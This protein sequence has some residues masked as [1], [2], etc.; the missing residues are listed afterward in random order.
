MLRN[1]KRFMEIDL[2]FKDKSTELWKRPVIDLPL[3]DAQT[4]VGLPFFSEEK[5]PV[6]NCCVGNYLGI[7]EI[8]AGLDASCGGSPLIGG[9]SNIH[10]ELEEYL[11]DQ[12]D[13]YPVLFINVTAA[14]QGLLQAIT[15]PL[16]KVSKGNNVDVI[17]ADKLNHSCLME[18]IYFAK[19]GFTRFYEHN[20]MRDLET[21]LAKYSKNNRKVLILTD[22]VFSME[23]DIAPLDEI[24][25]LA[26]QYG[27]AVIVDDAHAT[28]ILG[29]A[30]KGTCDYYG[31]VGDN[32]PIQI[33]SFSKGIGAMGAAV[34]VDEEF[35]SFLW[36]NCRN[37]I[38]CG[39]LTPEAAANTLRNLKI[40]FSESEHRTDLLNRANQ[41]RN[42]LI[43]MGYRVTGQ[44]N[45]IPVHIGDDYK[46]QMMCR[47]LFQEFGVYCRAIE[48]PAVPEA[49]LR[50]TLNAKHTQKQIDWI[51]AA[52]KIVGLR[53]EIL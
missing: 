24:T 26:N 44:Q 11:K 43:G 46:A 45:I 50:F 17:L 15:R 34:I 8:H 7:G 9:N 28:G 32:R 49:L 1:L 18:A 12:Y 22:G 25:K 47:D 14:A 21:K 39:T 30:G 10:L 6:I 53:Y 20:D 19:V 42:G 37:Y 16:W 31:L 33:I 29:P 40:A 52:M 36:R 51:L 27:A 48:Y 38:F 23:G 3:S 41:L 4:D 2:S 35:A 13:G 5:R